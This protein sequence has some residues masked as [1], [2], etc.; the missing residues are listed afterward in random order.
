MRHANMQMTIFQVLCFAVYLQENPYYM[1]LINIDYQK[2]IG[3]GRCVKIC[4]SYLFEKKN[5]KIEV[6]SDSCISCGHCVAAC[7]VDAISHSEFGESKV[8]AFDR[9]G[10]P[11]IEQVDLLMKSR[12]SNRAFSS[13]PVDK[14]FLGRIV[15]AA[16]RAPTASNLQELEIVVVTD[17]KK[18]KEISRITVDTFYSLA[19]KLGSPLARP[20]VKL[21]MPRN[22]GF[23]SKFKKMKEEYDSGVDHILRGA[24][25]VIFFIAPKGSRF[26]C[27]DANLAYQNASLMAEACGVAHFYTGFVCTAISMDR[28]RRIEKMFG[29]K[30]KIQAGMALGMPL[31][32][33]DKYID[34]K[35][36]SV[37]EF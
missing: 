10:L 4:P 23:I 13:A 33:F 37:R 34:K 12:R 1:V 29:I 22:Y 16:H 14:S 11:T 9:T 27:Q 17:E 7:P 36:L 21:F 28:K 2:C 24:K 35:D 25:A 30:G 5:G 18:I 6:S 31:F 32:K 19:S 15:E 8:H 26:G 20:V 3:C